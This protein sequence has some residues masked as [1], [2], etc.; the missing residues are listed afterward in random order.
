MR[1]AIPGT[2]DRATGLGKRNKTSR[3]WRSSGQEA[4]EGP[5]GREG[6]LTQATSPIGWP[7]SCGGFSGYCHNFKVLARFSLFACIDR[8]AWDK[9]KRCLSRSH[10]LKAADFADTRGFPTYDE[11][12]ISTLVSTHYPR[13][14]EVCLADALS[15]RGCWGPTGLTS[16]AISHPDPQGSDDKKAE[17]RGLSQKFLSFHFCMPKFGHASLRW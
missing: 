7:R 17:L 4:F 12:R 14:F 1:R 10:A 11:P 13:P 5:I 8:I 2:M 6:R 15:V 3:R 16:D 9:G